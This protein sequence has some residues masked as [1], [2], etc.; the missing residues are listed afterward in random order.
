MKT[1]RYLFYMMLLLS[2]I[3]VQ[4]GD[5]SIDVFLDYLQQKGFYDIIQAVKI[6]FGDDIA[7]DVCKEL[8]PT[9]D[10][11]TVVRVGCI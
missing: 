7:I 1:I 4:G 6:Y 2:N 3:E 10:C 11:E 8:A 9:I 5:Y